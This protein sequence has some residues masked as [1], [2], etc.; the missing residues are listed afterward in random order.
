MKIPTDYRSGT[1][2]SEMLHKK[3][4]IGANG[5]ADKNVFEGQLSSLNYL[6]NCAH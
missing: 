4:K 3:E 5:V 1:S 2:V 6:V